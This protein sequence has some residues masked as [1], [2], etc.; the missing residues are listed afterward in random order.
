MNQ[1][2]IL[3]CVMG[4]TPQ[5]VTETLFA[6]LHAGCPLPDEVHVLTTAEGAERARL[7]LLNDHW[8][9]RLFEDYHQTAPD[10]GPETIH[11]LT[12]DSGQPLVDIRTQ[13]DNRC[14]ADRITDLIR[15]FTL[16]PQ[17]QLHVSIAGGRKT[18]GFYAGY[19]LSLYGRLQDRL[20]H[21]LVS[22]DYENHPQF[23]YPTPKDHTIYGND[24]TH[25]PLNTKQAEVV[26]ADIDFVRLRYGLDTALL[27]GQ[28]SFRAAVERAQAAFNPA[29]L[30]IDCVRRT[31]EA[32][33]VLIPLRPAEFAFYLWILQRQTQQQGLLFCPSEG[34]P[35]KEYAQQYL[36]HYPL[37]S[38]HTVYTERTRAALRQGMSKSF[39]EQRKSRIN[40]QLRDVLQHAAL[41]YLI[42]AQG[43]RPRTGYRIDLAPEQIHMT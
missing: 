14:M 41:P 17:Y 39:F 21:V 2:R 6:L 43:Q 7:T 27:E 8:Y 20:T 29:C 23:Y 38:E 18:M 24:K 34:A 28:S 9:A 26:L 25:K 10:F 32:H 31:F 42:T 4:L 22:A 19:A 12:D 11:V 30:Q 35:D 40:K 13:A 36:E 3:L 16:N 15:R 33:G 37:L 5:V 1:K